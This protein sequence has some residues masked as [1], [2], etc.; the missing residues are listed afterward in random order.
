LES[1]KDF[2]NNSDL[3][4]NKCHYLAKNYEQSLAWEKENVSSYSIGIVENNE[5]LARN[6]FSPIHFD[7]ETASLNSL[8]FNDIF[9]KGLSVLR[10]NYINHEQIVSIGQEKVKNDLENGKIDRQYKGYVFV[11]ASKIRECIFDLKR[12]IAIYDTALS[13]I[14]SHADMC[15]IS[16]TKGNRNLLRIFL[17]ETFSKLIPVS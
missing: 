13:N 10:L 1:A 12:A 2:F 3:S 17:R 4:S 5:S 11:E 14:S 9:D 7:K 8:A 15:N 6:I 16:V